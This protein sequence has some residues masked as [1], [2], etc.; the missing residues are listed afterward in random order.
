MDQEESLEGVLVC[1]HCRAPIPGSGGTVVAC[2]RCGFNTFAV[3]VGCGLGVHASIEA[4]ALHPGPRR[5]WFR[6][7]RSG[8]SFTHGTGEWNDRYQDI[9]RAGDWYQERVTETRTGRI[10][11]RIAER[12]SDHRGH[13]SDRQK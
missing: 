13:G 2:P 11:H 6:R 3:A 9:D 1:G 8:A 12:L 5:R 4:L 7:I 10:I